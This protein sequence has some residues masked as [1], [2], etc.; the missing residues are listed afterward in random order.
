MGGFGGSCLR[1]MGGTGGLRLTQSE[2]GALHPSLF[3]REVQQEGLPQ[4][5]CPQGGTPRLTPLSSAEAPTFL[6]LRDTGRPSSAP[7]RAPLHPTAFS[8][9]SLPKPAGVG[10]EIWVPPTPRLVP[11]NFPRRVPELQPCRGADSPAR[12]P[13]GAGKSQFGV[14]PPPPAPPEGHKSRG[15]GHPVP[16]AVTHP[17]CVF[18]RWPG[19]RWPSPPPQQHPKAAPR[20]R[21]R[22]ALGVP[23][24]PREPRG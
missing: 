8:G 16:P 5:R 24:C 2:D 3:W 9:G 20:A 13:R 7:R 19:W 14:R 1:V 4:R 22:A 23:G 15:G 10:T 11:P 21:G 6:T 17:S 18:A 12:H